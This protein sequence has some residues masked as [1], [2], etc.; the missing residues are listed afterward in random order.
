M[1]QARTISL[2][3]RSW[4][5]GAS[6]PAGPM[7]A[8]PSSTSTEPAAALAATHGY[9]ARTALT[10]CAWHAATTGTAQISAKPTM[11]GASRSQ[12]SLLAHRDL[13]PHSRDRRYARDPARRD[14]RAVYVRELHTQPVA[15][16]G[17]PE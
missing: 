8:E 7:S 11:A 3:A 16:V 9:H 6:S 5:R 12:H 10:R 4:S 2:R 15:R 13:Q 14:V 17:A 1:P